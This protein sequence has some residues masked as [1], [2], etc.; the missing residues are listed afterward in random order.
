MK[1]VAVQR[2]Y[3]F[4]PAWWFFGLGKLGISAPTDVLKEVRSSPNEVKPV[5]VVRLSRWAG[6]P[7]PALALASL[8]CGCWALL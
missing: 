2:G 4:E 1:L 3:H 6:P 5:A 8:C 7:P